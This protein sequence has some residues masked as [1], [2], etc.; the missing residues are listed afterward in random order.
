VSELGWEYE[1]GWDG[2]A[3][4][5]QWQ[6]WAGARY[7]GELREHFWE[8]GS[9]ELEVIRKR[10]NFLPR[11]LFHRL[12]ISSNSCCCALASSYPLSRTH[13]WQHQTDGLVWKVLCLHLL[14]RPHLSLRA[15]RNN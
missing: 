4:L 15:V 13:R 7:G 6:R 1:L 11:V 9:D 5:R 3:F 12:H 10:I 2:G 8:S 14:S